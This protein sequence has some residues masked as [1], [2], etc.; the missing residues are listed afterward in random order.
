MIEKYCAITKS[1]E[2]ELWY[3][4]LKLALDDIKNLL[5]ALKRKGTVLWKDPI[6]CSDV[7]FL[8]KYFRSKSSDER[9]F[10]WN[11]EILGIDPDHLRDK[12][13]KKYLQHL[14]KGQLMETKTETKA[15][16]EKKETYGVL[17]VTLQDNIAERE[18]KIADQVGIPA[19]QLVN[20]I[21]MNHFKTGS[22]D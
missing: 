8:K 2:L 1:P 14:E 21:L 19:V 10:I 18:R 4:V 5:A 9:S 13:E 12:V 11:C 16:D 7:K 15:I 17:H 3:C 6:F 20:L 22:V